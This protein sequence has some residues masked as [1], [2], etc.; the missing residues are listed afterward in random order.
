[1]KGYVIICQDQ[2]RDDEPFFCHTEILNGG[3]IGLYA[4]EYSS[5]AAIYL[6][7]AGVSRV[8]QSLVRTFSNSSFEILEIDLNDMDN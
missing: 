1:M 3:D 6:T 8:M 2:S 4:Q 5:D 7:L